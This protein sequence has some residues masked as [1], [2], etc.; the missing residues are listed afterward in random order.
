MEV[1]FNEEGCEGDGDTDQAV[2]IPDPLLE[3]EVHRWLSKQEGPVTRKDLADLTSLEY[4]N[5]D[6]NTAESTEGLCAF[7]R[8]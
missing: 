6:G 4:E 5:L 1:I 8:G 2:E 7:E 3:R